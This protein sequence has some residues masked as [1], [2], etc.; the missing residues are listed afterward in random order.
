MNIEDKAPLT[1]NYNRTDLR[2]VVVDMAQSPTPDG[3]QARTIA[4]SELFAQ[5]EQGREVIPFEALT[6]LAW[7]VASQPRVYLDLTAD[8]S[9][10]VT[11]NTTNGFYFELHARQLQG[12]GKKLTIDGV[13][14][15]I[16]RTGNTLI[17]ARY[18]GGV[19][20]IHTDASAE[21]GKPLLLD[22]SVSQT[23]LEGEYAEVWARFSGADDYTVER[24]GKPVPEAT[25]AALLVK[26]AEQTA[27]AY[28]VIARNDFGETRSA[29]KFIK[30]GEAES[31]YV[32][33]EPADASVPAGTEFT[34][35]A[36][37]AGTPPP[38][39]KC[40]EMVNGQAG[41][42]VGNSGSYKATSLYT[43]QYQFTATN[44]YKVPVVVKPAVLGE[45]GVTVVTSAVTEFQKKTFTAV[46]KIVTVTP[47][48]QEQ[49]APSIRMDDS[50]VQSYLQVTLSGSDAST[51]YEGSLDVTAANAVI[52]PLT[53]DGKLVVGDINLNTGKA[54][55]RKKETLVYNA[56][57]WATNQ[58]PF[59]GTLILPPTNLQY[60]TATGVISWTKSVDTL[61]P[62]TQEYCLDYGSGST[63]ADIALN[64]FKVK[65]DIPAGKFA[66]REKART[67]KPASAV[68]TNSAKYTAPDLMKDFVGAKRN[69]VVSAGT[70][71]SVG[72]EDQ[73]TNTWA[74]EAIETGS[75]LPAGEEGFV[76]FA[77][78]TSDLNIDWLAYGLCEDTQFGGLSKLFAGYQITGV[79]VICFPTISPGYHAGSPPPSEYVDKVRI[80]RHFNNPLYKDGSFRMTCLLNQV[81]QSTLGRPGTEELVAEFPEEVNFKGDLY[82]R[83][84]FNEGHTNSFLNGLRTYNF[85][86]KST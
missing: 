57:A 61:S 19:L 12:G 21:A 82:A 56:S 83:I 60:N 72:T 3:N 78:G 63:W 35:M 36:A 76:E 75:Y 43:K 71:F 18:I 53:T 40:V 20:D 51:N 69:N 32:V 1:G 24:D 85:V 38:A 23:V 67:G 77:L 27:G 47:I 46:S 6:S 68:L 74:Y 30:P 50:T 15:I 14:V 42:T 16:N 73:G 9:H 86:A 62:P 64:S 37:F 13:P 84:C 44:A 66:V 52:V 2:L 45:D 22:E 48:K 31:V 11:K 17:I 10:I 81:G 58:Q 59:T 55:I 65:A 8:L 28:E 70:M 54:G 33:T 5:L 49:A 34:L 26:V 79:S 39:I 4:A 41:Q 80:W 25:G 29:A 7:N